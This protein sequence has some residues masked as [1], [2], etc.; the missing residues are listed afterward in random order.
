MF[1]SDSSTTASPASSSTDIS[2]DTLTKVASEPTSNIMKVPAHRSSTKPDRDP[3]VAKKETE[4][5]DNHSTSGEGLVQPDTQT[6]LVADSAPT[7]DPA[8]D[9]SDTK[10]QIRTGNRLFRIH[11][12]KLNEFDGLRPKL[13]QA[14]K[15]DEEQKTIELQDDADDFHNLLV[16]LYS[17]VY[18]F[19]LFSS[20][21]LK[22]TLKLASK[23]AH[24]T[25]RTF[26][27]KELEKHTLE[28]IDRFALSRDCDVTEWMVK[29][30]DDLCWREQSIT[31]AEAK[32]LGPEKFVEVAARRE[33][34]KFERGSRVVLG[35][36]QPTQAI[37][38]NPEV[39][40][41][42]SSISQ[43]LGGI[44]SASNELLT[45]T[46]RNMQPISKE[47][48]GSVIFARQAT[49]S[50]VTADN[51]NSNVHAQPIAPAPEFASS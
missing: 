15:D 17:S 9:F 12:F 48:S 25:L 42:S 27:I 50:Q 7:C 37:K 36:G 41:S 51:P 24:L 11:Q 4:P 31:V 2:W 28:P 29:A 13:E 3:E 16:V 44:L 30:I 34:I 21:T 43:D 39:S 19:H 33:E 8:F 10:I 45:A 26:A 46:S 22:S 35:S 18:D 5:K 32:I 47:L 38:A 6:T 23:Y 14:T 40:T 49:S 1:T 20:A